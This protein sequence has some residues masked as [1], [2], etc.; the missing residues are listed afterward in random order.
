M[1][2]SSACP[3][4]SAAHDAPAAWPSRHRFRRVGAAHARRA[5]WPRGAGRPRPSAH[6]R[7]APL[8]AR[9][10]VRHPR[11]L[12]PGSRGGASGRA[13]SRRRRARV[14]ITS[15][16]PTARASCTRASA[17]T[18]RPPRHAATGSL[19]RCRERGAPGR[20]AGSRQT[21]APWRRPPPPRRLSAPSRCSRGSPRRSPGEGR[22]VSRARGARSMAACTGQADGLHHAVR[23]AEPLGHPC[24]RNAGERARSF[25]GMAVFSRLAL[26]DAAVTATRSGMSLTTCRLRRVLPLFD[27]QVRTCSRP[28]SRPSRTAG[29]AQCAAQ[30]ECSC[31]YNAKNNTLKI[32]M[33]CTLIW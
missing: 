9:C 15:A 20:P 3:P 13:A 4:S 7:R 12:S 26:H 11:P 8:C 19:W 28:C 21:W 32:K 29:Y 22:V 14:S 1:S 2:G 18:Q 30:E 17:T 31:Q 5:P 27:L 6:N 10:A 24:D 33:W 16:A 25:V 23:P